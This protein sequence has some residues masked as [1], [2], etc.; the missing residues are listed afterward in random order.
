MTDKQRNAPDSILILCTGNS[1]RSQMAEGWFRHY[2]PEGTVVRSAGIEAHGLNPRAV[3]VMNEKGIDI[4]SHTSNR[5][6]EYDDE[7]FDLVLTVCDNAKER[8]PIYPVSTRTIHHSFPDPA[9]AT[10]S[11]EEIVQVFRD[12]RDAIETYVEE[13][14]GRKEAG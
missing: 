6:E 11:E 3:R 8:C 10:G 14:A 2:M 1:C 12:V 9:D 13:F 5:I 4:T 7:S